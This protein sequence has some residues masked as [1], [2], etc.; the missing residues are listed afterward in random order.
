MK[1]EAIITLEIDEDLKNEIEEIC[2]KEGISLDTAINFFIK[3]ILETK[4]FLLKQMRK[5]TLF[6]AKKIRKN[7]LK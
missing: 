3:K 5:M 4:N 6:I 7:L 2:N 1:K